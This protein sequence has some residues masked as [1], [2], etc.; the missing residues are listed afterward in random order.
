MIT[1]A[2]VHNQGRFFW[3]VWHKG[4]EGSR[5]PTLQERA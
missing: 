4:V 1:E 5:S 2:Y 3:G